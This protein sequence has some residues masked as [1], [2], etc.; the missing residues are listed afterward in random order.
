MEILDLENLDFIKPV[1]ISDIF[2]RCFPTKTY[3]LYKSSAY[4]AMG[5]HLYGGRYNPKITFPALYFAS[6]QT[7][8]ALETEYKNLNLN[9]PNINTL[10]I[11]CSKIT[12]NVLDLTDQSNLQKLNLNQSDL[13]TNSHE[14][15][16]R[17]GIRC[18]SDTRFDGIIYPSFAAKEFMNLNYPEHSNLVIFMNDKDMRK[19]KAESC[20]IELI[21]NDNFLQTYESFD[22]KD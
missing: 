3:T 2:Y 22:I 14:L 9:L 1:Q 6:S 8:A 15:T 20:S 13:L 18:S 11:A 21:D 12:A 17:I 16:Q 10:I 7:L 19:P 5:S 4:S